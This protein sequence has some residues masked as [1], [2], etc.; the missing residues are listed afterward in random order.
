MFQDKKLVYRAGVIPYIIENGDVLMMFMVP[1]EPAYGGQ[2]P[3]LAK[4]KVEED[5]T[6][7]QAALREGAEE[8]GLFK[9][10]C[11]I[12]EEVGLFMGRTTVFVSKIKDK[13]MFGSP[14]FETESTMW[15]TLEQFMEQGRPLHK[16]VVQAAHRT[17]LKIESTNQ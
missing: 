7:M 1:S 2:E 14:G 9:G 10:N 11:I 17:I 8:V 15:L 6:M 16:P 4:G 13:D 5:E 12:T 3:Q